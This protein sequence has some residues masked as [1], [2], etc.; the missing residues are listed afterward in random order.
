MIDPIV[1]PP[2]AYHIGPVPIVGFGLGVIGGFVR[3]PRAESF[4]PIEPRFVVASVSLAVASVEF[5]T[6]SV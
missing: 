2:F 5:A 3:T 4:A 6:P 1:H